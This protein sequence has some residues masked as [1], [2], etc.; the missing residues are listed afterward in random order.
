MKFRPWHGVVA[1]LWVVAGGWLLYSNYQVEA[2]RKAF[3][4]LSCP[5]CHMAGGA[6]NLEHVGTKYDRAALK[7]FIAN[8][9]VVYARTGGKT[10]NKGYPPM[11]RQQISPRQA[12]LISRF[13]AT[14]E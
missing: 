9:E 10:L 8:P 2:G 13:L 5:S 6:P 3:Q 11:P 14:L 7:E 12:E 1:A 4:S